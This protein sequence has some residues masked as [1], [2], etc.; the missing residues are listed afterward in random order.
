MSGGP[1]SLEMAKRITATYSLIFLKEAFVCWLTV[2]C[3]NT[4]LMGCEL[5]ISATLETPEK[6]DGKGY[7]FSY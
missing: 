2:C 7:C 4:L 5:A 6:R 1:W 3:V